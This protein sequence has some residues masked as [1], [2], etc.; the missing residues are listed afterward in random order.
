MK[1]SLRR[2]W[3]NSLSPR[4]KA[5]P[6][7]RARR[8][9]PEIGP[10]ISLRFLSVFFL[11]LAAAF[12]ARADLSRWI[13]DIALPDRLQAVFFRSMPMPGGAIDVRR[14]PRETRAELSKLITAAPADRALYA[15]R[16]R[17]DEM[18]LD[19]VAAEDDW[20]KSGDTLALADFYHR[21]IKPREEIAALEVGA[22]A[23]ANSVEKLKP[24]TEQSSWKAFERIQSVVAE[25]ALPT[26]VSIAGYRVWVARYP[27]EPAAYRQF[28]NAVIAAKQF[29]E[30]DRILADYRRAFPAD[31]VYPVLATAALAAARGSSEDALRLY[32]QSFRPLWPQEL[33]KAYFDQLKQAHALRRFQEQARAQVAAR[34]TDIAPAARLYYYHQQ[35]G[36]AEPAL[37]ALY[38]YRQRKETAKSAWSADELWTLGQLFE[39]AHNYDDAARSYLALYNIDNI[40]ANRQERSLA[41]IAN[42]LL[43]APDQPV[44]FGSG[45]LSFYR[46]IATMDPGPGFLNGILSL[47]FNSTGPEYQYQSENQASVSYFHRAK[48][49]ELISEFDRRFPNAPERPELHAKLI[50]A[51]VTYGDDVG[52]LRAG[53]EFL[54][55]FPKAPQRVAVS[56]NIADAYVRQNKAKEEFAVYDDLLKELAAAA[57][58]VPLGERAGTA[59][60]A[61]DKNPPA[62]SAAL[63]VRSPEYAR[64]LDRYIARLV[65]LKRLNDALGI[66]RREIDRNANDPGLY[67]QLAGFLQQNKLDAQVE[68]V[69]RKAMAQFQDR[70]WSHKLARWYLRR[71]QVAQFDM[72]TRDVVKIFSGTELESYLG[73]VGQGQ[74]LGAILFKQVNVY[75]H[76]RFPYDLMFVRNLLTAYQTKGTV[77][78][79]AS[80]AL[81]RANWYHAPDLRDRFFELLS[82]TGKLK[83]EL[84]SLP[85]PNA[86]AN[87]AAA[88][89]VAEAEAW[90]S[91]FEVAAPLF[92]T[93]AAEYPG[94]AEEQ[95]RAASLYRS[96]AT[97]DA[98]G[99]FKN[100][101]LASSLE[102]N[103]TRAAP[104]DTGAL[105]T[106]GEIYAD[107]ERFGRAKPYWDRIAAVAPGKSDGYLESATVYWDYYRFDDANRLIAEGRRKLA[108]N[109]LFSYEAGAIA[110]NRRDY[111]R[112]LQ[113][114]A[115]GAL[116][117]DNPASRDRLVAL[118]RRDTRR[119]AIEDLTAK[120]AAGANAPLAAVSLRVDVLSAQNRTDDLSSFLLATATASGLPEVLQYV[121]ENATTRALDNVLEQAKL[122][123]LA[124]TTDPIERMQA[125][126]ALLH[127]Y[128][129][130]KNI[131]AAQRI[132]DTLYKNNPAVLGV[133][134]TAVDFAWRNRDTKR[135]IDILTQAAQRAQPAY[136]NP[137]TLEAARKATEA[138]DYNRARGFLNTLLA[139]ASFQPEYVAA[140]AD[141]YARQNDDKGLRDFFTDR[142]KTAKS[143]QAAALRR[144]LI[145]VLTRLK[146]Y[147]GAVD[148]YIEVLNRYAEDG[149]LAQEAAAYAA[150][151]GRAQ[152]L[153]AYYQN[154]QKQSPKDFRWP[155][156]EARIQVQLENFP[157]AVS[158][159]QRAG[160]IRPDRLE[161]YTERA[162][163]E[164]RL[165]RFDEA[166]AT[167][168]KLYELNYHNSQWMERVAAV[169]ARQGQ[170]DAAVKALSAAL[171]DGRPARPEMFFAV[172]Q[173]LESWNMLPQAKDFAEKG[174]AA[175]GDALEKDYSNSAG[176]YVRIMTR[177]RQYD[178][179]FQKVG[180][181]GLE[182]MGMVVREYF[183]PDEKVA[184]VA[185]IGPRLRVFSPAIQAAGLL[186]LQVR[187]YST[188]VPEMQQLA[189]LQQRRLMFG[190]LGGQLLAYWKTLKPDTE[191]RD[192]YLT[193]AADNYR[194]AGD[195]A[196]ESRVLLQLFQLGKLDGERMDRVAALI[197]VANSDAAVNYFLRKGT[198]QQAMQAVV[199][200]GK[201]LPP[202]WTRA[203]MALTGLY[204]NVN[205]PPVNAAFREVLD[206]V[207]I[208]DRM[209]KKADRNQTLA[210]D[211]WFYYGSRYGEYLDSTKQP[212]AEDYLPAGVEARPGS[213]DAYFALGEYYRERGQWDRAREEYG[214]AQQ[215]APRRIDVH[216]GLAGI[217]LV[218]NQ[219]NEAI[220]EFKTA[221][222]LATR[223]QNERRLPE[224][225]WT[226]LGSIVEQLAA[227]KL[228]EPMRPDVD[229]VVRTYVSRTGQYRTDEFMPQLGVPWMLTLS[230]AAPDPVQFLAAEVAAPWIPDAERAAVYRALID[231]VKNKPEQALDLRRYQ[232]DFVKYLLD[233]KRA[234]EAQ[235]A[236][237]EIPDAARRDMGNQVIPLEVRIAAQASGLPALLNRYAAGSEVFSKLD[238]IRNGATELERSGDHASARQV[239]EFVYTRQIDARNLN[240]ATFLGLAGIRLEQN[241]LPAALALLRRMTMVVGEPF[242]NLVDAANLLVRTGH[243]QE[244]RPFLEQRV[245]AVPWDT[246]AR[247]QLAKVTGAND[248]LK[249]LAAA[250]EVPY[251]T[252]A[253]A[254]APAPG[255]KPYAYFERLAAAA[256]AKEAASR[257][258]LLQGAIAIDPA[259]ERPKLDLI[260]AA[261]EARR[262]QA[263]VSAAE[264]NRPLV[265]NADAALLRGLAQAY[266]NLDTL[267]KAEE[268]YRKADALADA[269]RVQAILYLRAENDARRPVV[270]KNLEQNGPVRPRLL[271]ATGG[272]R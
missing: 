127:F 259:P 77:D 6:S 192:S 193:M 110:E 78:A 1:W 145:P 267:L 159:Y 59:Q 187:Y 150:R 236:L 111:D 268:L 197:P 244:A 232:L 17:E 137:F 146:D 251:E 26:D 69:Y 116:S 184:F 38:E 82:R 34:P 112:A 181:V 25:Q 148:Q 125:Q 218:R 238:D 262:W 228:L 241:D 126:I 31:E 245:K 155:L 16:A 261:I 92:R 11:L 36:N 214:S 169:R 99:D 165:L 217:A 51:Y 160:E 88:R 129:G 174:V 176:I 106:V 49:S 265:E 52:V 60:P 195:G 211:L 151:H 136:R 213:A 113:E 247:V 62:R 124:L 271:V 264:Q 229:R 76:Q 42:L 144:G 194:L 270:T 139:Q 190:D 172:A 207:T 29:G 185:F 85:A 153:V 157:A 177:L 263:A 123:E 226:D 204:F 230:R 164:E 121:E 67:E 40:G 32:D 66:Y 24:V 7:A 256:Q 43:T 68:P 231:A 53:R 216:V 142:L 260:R 70:S 223:I 188:V 183:T 58:H 64:V 227:A 96:L 249:A 5:C 48:A 189:S 186:D 233:R 163:L 248:V 196:A 272:V 41:A 131:A 175:A 141:T 98:P 35:Q 117:G 91:H 2:P 224:S 143:E 167:Y 243:A 225:F 97:Y 74:A 222:S 114:Y 258:R 210:G 15:L 56:L 201:A 147:P 215:L 130:R 173:R 95:T 86:A 203:Y 162:S 14:P 199:A 254:V 10:V 9:S 50:A 104:R 206:A 240:T 21:R 171:L 178:A 84:A 30:V 221:L 161:F 158:A 202:V 122:R 13:Q 87:P 170:T 140:M 168:S 105:A 152:Q 75:A 205:T 3:R 80:E 47:L 63:P 132:I 83:T 93:V 33:V 94:D 55:A 209:A 179:A 154:T 45:D 219:R 208:G 198:A 108:N 102:Q 182:Q 115:K 119:A 12:T 73:D 103:A 72:L 237:S 37:R 23:P 191:N 18:Q 20:K 166:V 266:E 19:F 133:V 234:V 250:S 109:L 61:E 54:S 253:A 39:G 71:K 79:A 138:G 180:A 257:V 46:D 28:L 44:R 100:T 235:V 255:E 89:F 212:D 101:E 128:E 149:A 4:A 246:S 269:N 57:D 107:R 200:R 239:L 65:E 242:E 8:R 135:S 27:V 252:R 22:R 90:Q 156:V 134:R 220:A 118:A 120:A 81:L